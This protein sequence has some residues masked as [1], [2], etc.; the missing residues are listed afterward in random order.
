MWALVLAS[1]SVLLGLV[2]GFNAFTVLLWATTLVIAIV[3]MR[4]VHTGRSG[5]RSLAVLS[6]VFAGVAFLAMIVGS[7]ATS[8]GTSAVAAPVVAP[9]PARTITDREWQ[10][11]ARDP[12]SHRG[13][14]VIVHGEVFQAD[15][16]TGTDTVMANVS[17]QPS[18]SPDSTAMVTGPVSELV[19][20]DTFTAE[21]EVGGAFEYTNMMGGNVSAPKLTL[22]KLR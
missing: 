17:G 21:V 19:E 7:A 16:M 3:A 2:L 9:Q 10:Q 6:V 20:G 8:A 22:L 18:D 11:I 4:R 1:L 12:D 15:S 13:E 14:R 5:G